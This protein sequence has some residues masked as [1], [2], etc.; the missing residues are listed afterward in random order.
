MV[1]SRIQSISLMEC[2]DPLLSLKIFQRY[3]VLW[4]LFTGAE[5]LKYFYPFH[6]LNSLKFYGPHLKLPRFSYI[7]PL[8]KFHVG[9]CSLATITVTSMRTNGYKEQRNVN[10]FI[11]PKS[12]GGIWLGGKYKKIL[13]A[14]DEGHKI[15]G[16]S[17]DA[18]QIPLFDLGVIKI[19]TFRCSL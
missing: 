4:Y 3:T 18:N 15:W 17:I 19:F 16:N 13:G 9:M 10:I 14:S 11:T 7:F 1:V 2:P 6:R 8:I 5:E 12:K